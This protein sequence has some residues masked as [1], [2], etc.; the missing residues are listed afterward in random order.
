[1]DE[2][3]IPGRWHRGRFYPI[4][5]GAEEPRAEDQSPAPAAADPTPASTS[6]PPEPSGP[7]AQDLIRTFEDPQVRAQVDE[8][9]RTTYQPYVTGLEQRAAELEQAAGLVEALR[10]D[11]VGT[12]LE[13]TGLIG[14]EDLAEEVRAL[15]TPEERAEA[16]AQLEG[17]SQELDPRVQELIEEREQEKALAEYEKRLEELDVEPDIFHPLVIAHEGDI[18]AAYAAYPGYLEAVKR[19]I[20]EQGGPTPDEVPAPP[21]VIGSDTQGGSTPPLENKPAT[22][23]DALDQFFAAQ[24][25]PQT[26]GSV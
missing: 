25:A 13:L 12:Y 22:L 2:T 11:P 23:D 4:M 7:W 19:A 14:G 17:Q 1:M 6:S 5:A 3:H 8:F 15:L 18:D 21:S 20:S 24:K 16:A 26:V 9:M 10:E